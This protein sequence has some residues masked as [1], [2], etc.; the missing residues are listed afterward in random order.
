MNIFSVSVFLDSLLLSSMASPR[1]ETFCCPNRDK[2]T[3]FVLDYQPIFFNAV[4][5]SSA[6]ISLFFTILQILP[7]KRLGY[8]R[9]GQY[10]LPKPASSSRILLIITVC[11][12]L[13]CAGII[14][15]SSVWLGYTDFSTRISVVNGTEVWPTAFCVA[16]S[17]WIQLFYGASFWWLFCY[18]IDA[19]LVVRRSA[20]LSTIVLYHILAWG[21][22]VL[23]CVEGV[24]M[25]YY[26]S[27]FS[28]ED[29]LEHAIPHYTTTYAPLLL[30]LF[31]N[32]ILY[33]R[34]IT[35]VAS[36]LKGR[37]GVYSE[38]ERRLGTEIKVRF[39]KMMLV[40]ILC[41]L[42]NIVNECL[43]FYLEMQPDI[44][45]SFLKDVRKAALVTWFIM[46]MLNPMQG[47]LN[48]LAFHGWTGCDF[49]LSFQSKELTWESP[50][51][52]TVEND[53]A[54]SAGPSL[55]Y[56]GYIQDAK[57]ELNGN[58]FQSHE[59]SSLLSEGS[60]AS[61]VELYISGD[62]RDIKDLEAG[63]KSL[64]NP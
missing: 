27:V 50:T 7:K 22:A 1:L 32:P 47:L 38:N 42:P 57:N 51:S 43:L 62:P 46:G 20:G 56:K 37:Q 39:F 53:F 36:L 2:A 19:Y 52:T 16:S 63:A 58:G 28:C 21:L 55:H 49:D 13:G 25:L 26:P 40:F 41:W 59:S 3:Q 54:N 8:K 33:G 10:P 44:R 17:M 29:G 24:T 15:R 60:E 45:E 61:T 30:V 9:L 5:L 4:C 48:A 23:L 12:I 31:V 64:E 11:D 34:T 18:A 14:T 35:A 6:T